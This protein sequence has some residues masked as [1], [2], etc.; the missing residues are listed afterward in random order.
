M[1]R[2]NEALGE[3]ARDPQ[4]CNPA[5]T[6]CDFCRRDYDPD[7]VKTF[8]KFSGEGTYTK[9]EFCLDDNSPY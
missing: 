4:I 8:P 2:A 7:F 5:R 9:C 6:H 1:K 3:H